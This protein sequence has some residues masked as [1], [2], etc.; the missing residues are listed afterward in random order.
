MRRLLWS[1]LD[2]PWSEWVMTIAHRFMYQAPMLGNVAFSDCF[3]MPGLS[4]TLV[5]AGRSLLMADLGVRTEFQ[6]AAQ[7]EGKNSVNTEHLLR[8]AASACHPCGASQSWQ[9]FMFSN[10]WWNKLHTKL[11]EIHLS[12]IPD[13]RKAGDCP[14]LLSITRIKPHSDMQLTTRE[15]KMN[16]SRPQ[17]IHLIYVRI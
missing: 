17:G 14:L 15:D 6:Q 2:S 9:G 1:S 8:W 4:S 10:V 3:Y 12:P 11:Q 7:D 13:N 16:T 5:S